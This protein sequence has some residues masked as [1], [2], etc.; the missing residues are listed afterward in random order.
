M[1]HY[2]PSS[3]IGAMFSHVDADRSGE[4]DKA[5]FARLYAKVGVHL[6]G[7]ELDSQF[8]M[9]DTD[10]SGTITLD[11]LQQHM[12]VSTNGRLA[13]PDHH[14]RAV[15]KRFDENRDGFLDIRE[16]GELYA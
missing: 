13:D 3:Q 8:R 1:S 7:R 9:Y 15:F 14:L 16:L 2:N 6:S 11:E 10:N 5:E 12:H 4:I